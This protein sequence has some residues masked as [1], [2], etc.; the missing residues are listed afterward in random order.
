MYFVDNPVSAYLKAGLT[1]GGGTVKN[2][3]GVTMYW[4]EEEPGA[5]P[6]VN[7]ETKVC[8]DIARWRET[9]HMPDLEKNC[10]DE[11]GW[12]KARQDMEAHR[13][14]QLL[15][16]HLA[17]GVFEQMHFLMGFEDTLVSF[18][19]EPEATAELIEYL[20][21][22]KI[23]QFDFIADRLPLEG[24]L[25]MDDWG[26]AKALFMSPDM[27]REFFKEPYKRFYGHIKER[28]MVLIHHADSYLFPIVEDMVDLGIDIWQG[29][30]QSNDLVQVQQILNG[31]MVIMGG[32][33]AA[34]DRQDSTEDEIRAHVRE[35][36]N[37]FAPGG[38]FIPCLT[39]GPCGSIYPHVDP[40]IDDE[41]RA[42]NRE[43][44]G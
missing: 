9:V 33:E 24:I 42:Y 4:G 14:Q 27:W 18:Y 3:W 35:A 22:W 41:V 30:L 39:Y 10:S 19:D 12:E 29:A 7:D 21:D 34:I 32:V 13:G 31:R 37:A 38:N 16:A 5:M 44:R 28:G 8:P 20:T 36:C 11:A 43:H 25:A 6:M 40:V 17:Q 15:C 1:R 23:K 26:S 2:P